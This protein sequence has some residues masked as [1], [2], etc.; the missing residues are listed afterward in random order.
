MFKKATINRSIVHL[1]TDQIIEDVERVC[2]DEEQRSKLYSCLDNKPPQD[3]SFSKVNTFLK[4]ADS[5]S[6]EKKHLETLAN[7]VEELIGEINEKINV[8]KTRIEHY[9]IRS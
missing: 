7:E 2:L 4:V 6:D 8:M 1:T 9:Q 3:Q 5:L